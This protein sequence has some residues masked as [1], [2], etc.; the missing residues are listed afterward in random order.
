MD[1]G[2]LNQGMTENYEGLSWTSDEYT[3]RD[4]Y[5]WYQEWFEGNVN[6]VNK[7]KGK[8]NEKGKG[9]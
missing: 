4:W 5:Q 3:D 6:A 2:Q 1:I 7:G 8:G 9:K